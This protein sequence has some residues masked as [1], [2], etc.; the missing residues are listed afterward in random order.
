MDYSTAQKEVAQEVIA[1]QGH[2]SRR[3]K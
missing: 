2:A 3:K 1:P